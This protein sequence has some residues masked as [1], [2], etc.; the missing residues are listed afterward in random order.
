MNEKDTNLNRPAETS[1]PQTSSSG[2]TANERQAL[3]D[4]IVR[5][6]RRDSIKEDVS[7]KLKKQNWRKRISEFFQHQAVL[8]V[9]GFAI[10]GWI[11]GLL[12]NRW[13]RKEWDR[14]QLE[15]SKEWERQQ[16]RLLDIKAVDLKYNLINEVTLRIGDRIAA[17]TGIVLPLYGEREN[18]ELIKEE[19]EPIKN[20][21]KVSNEWRV[22]SQVLKLKLAAHIKNPEASQIFDRI[23]TRET[24][25]AA[26]IDTV[27]DNLTLYNQRDEGDEEAEQ[28]VQEIVNE[29][30]ELAQDLKNLI[31]VITKEAQSDMQGHKRS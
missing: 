24:G 20:W 13:Q 16:L 30:K 22:S 3:I 18:Q 4:D 28:L 8:L 5:E 2:F 25:I 27:K 12:A 10:T 29:L 15:Q 26:K 6:I 9:I 21:H 11:G 7:S 31:D 14:Q 17:A 19:E 23:I 1:A